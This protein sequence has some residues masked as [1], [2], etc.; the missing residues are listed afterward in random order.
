MSMRYFTLSAV[1]MLI[2]CM[3]LALSGTTDFPGGHP[4]IAS[5]DGL[6]H[7]SSVPGQ[8]GNG[9]APASD[10]PAA[11]AEGGAATATSAVREHRLLLLGAVLIPAWV[12][13]SFRILSKSRGRP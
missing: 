11:G 2:F 4:E 10:Y 1:C 5:P 8:T 9:K 6:V 7:P 12:F 3:L 13:I